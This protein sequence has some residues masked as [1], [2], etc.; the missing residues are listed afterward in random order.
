[1]CGK[2]QTRREAASVSERARGPKQ[3]T[4]N[5]TKQEICSFL[6]FFLSFFLSSFLFVWSLTV[7]RGR[8]R[9]FVKIFHKHWFGKRQK[10]QRAPKAEGVCVCVCVCGVCVCVSVFS[11][12]VLPKACVGIHVIALP[13]PKYIHTH[14][15]TKQTHVSS[16]YVEKNI[17]A[18]RTVN[19]PPHLFSPPLL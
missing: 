6:S 9:Q 19:S 13:L 17:A 4:Q 12:P 3:Q 15:R 5:S 7:F 1:M 16:L 10:A 2:T 8:L 11:V 18:H 14:A